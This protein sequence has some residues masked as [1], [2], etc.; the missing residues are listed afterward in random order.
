MFSWFKKRLNVLL[1]ND[2]NNGFMNANLCTV[3]TNSKITI[4]KNVIG[5][6]SYKDKVYLEMQEGEYTINKENLP[7][8]YKRQGGNK[9][10]LKHIKVDFFFI[11]TKAFDINFSYTDKI[12]VNA[13]N[14]KIILFIGLI[15][16]TYFL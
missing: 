8:L 5:F 6:V 15:I 14:V 3:K 11:N 12:P 9:R 4:P 13:K 10:T 7:D 16:I 1:P 2:I